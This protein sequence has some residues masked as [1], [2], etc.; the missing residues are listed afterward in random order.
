MGDGEG[1]LGQREG[2][3]RGR[4]PR[5]EQGRQHVPRP[6]HACQVSVHCDYTLGFSC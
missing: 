5:G 4:R 2:R 3:R 1:P 6:H